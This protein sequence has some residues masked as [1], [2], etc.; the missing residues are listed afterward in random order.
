MNICDLCL[1]EN[2]SAGNKKFYYN[3]SKSGIMSKRGSSFLFNL[4][5]YCL[6][7]V[8]VVVVVA[9]VEFAS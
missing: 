8:V 4:D 7:A 9:A 5:S 1:T 3:F 6:G 2:V